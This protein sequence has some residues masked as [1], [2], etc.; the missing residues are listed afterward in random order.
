MA[1]DKYNY[2]AWQLGQVITPE[3]L[4]QIENQLV[5]LTDQSINQS[6]M[7]Q[8]HRERM[9]ELTEGDLNKLTTVGSYSIKTGDDADN[10]LNKPPNE[11]R[12]PYV[13]YVIKIGESKNF[14]IQ[15]GITYQGTIWIRQKNNNGWQDWKKISNN[16]DIEA[17]STT[18]QT[19]TSQAK[20]VEVNTNLN[21]LIQG[22][23]YAITQNVINGG[24]NIP[25]NVPGMLIVFKITRA[26]GFDIHQIY[27][28]DGNIWKRSKIY[29]NNTWS[30]WVS[31]IPSIEIPVQEHYTLVTP[32][33]ANVKWSWQDSPPSQE[34][35]SST[36]SFVTKLNHG[37]IIKIQKEKFDASKFQ[38]GYVITNN[39]Y[40]PLIPTRTFSYTKLVNA[41]QTIIDASQLETDE[42]KVIIQCRN[43]PGNGN[44]LSTS[45]VNKY[46]TI[47]NRDKVVDLFI[48]AGQSNM[49]G[50]ANVSSDNYPK[51]ID[52]AGLEYRAI[53]ADNKLFKIAEPFGQNQN[54]GNSTTANDKIY[55]GPAKTGGM[56]TSF[57]N[58]YYEKTGVPI[59]GIS[60]SQGGLS[61]P[62]FEGTVNDV[63]YS[64][65]SDDI[66]VR[67]NKAKTYLTNNHYVIRHKFLVWLQGESDVAKY[68][69][70]NNFNYQ[71]YFNSTIWPIFKTAGVEK[72][73]FIRI[74]EY[75]SVNNPQYN[76]YASIIMQQQTKLTQTNPDII[77]VSTLL[78]SYKSKRMMQTEWHYT[79]EAYN[80]FGTD[81]GI[82]AAY[83]VNTGKKPTM[84]DPKYYNLYPQ[85]YNISQDISHL[86]EIL[87]GSVETSYPFKT[88][89][90]LGRRGTGVYFNCNPAAVYLDGAS[91]R[92]VT[93]D[94]ISCEA[95]DIFKISACAKDQANS[96]PLGV[97]KHDANGDL[98]KNSI[99][100]PETKKPPE[101]KYTGNL[102][103]LKDYI[104]T[105]PQG[106]DCIVVN[107]LSSIEN[108]KPY[109]VKLSQDTGLNVEK[110]KSQLYTPEWIVPQ[111]IYG[112][113]GHP[114]S[115]YY[116]NT[117]W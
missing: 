37:S 89:T 92:Y 94:I 9:T 97:L 26:N 20:S 48:F 47:L 41:N 80:E 61:L 79:M 83:Y 75:E 32:Q 33:F 108:F 25:F 24:S 66:I 45:D 49:S 86:N 110:L 68:D 42:Y 85:Y 77:M 84:Y 7:L 71:D 81:A 18:I 104:Y 111:H 60:A 23:T 78:A 105:I 72:C 91:I 3:K 116:Y 12:T 117:L 44:P 38:F 73:F 51:L 69:P 17:L 22:G 113:V 55:D 101:N 11:N 76:D 99:L 10:I 102:I 28:T 5:T 15:L 50:R 1:L 74:G 56:V 4:N 19:I 35:N 109:V 2:Q 27:I 95:G 62:E 52:G 115:L 39:D 65:I 96:C 70:A 82:N 88:P 112:V 54:N 43:N 8:L 6:T 14:Y 63:T 36:T 21:N 57:V 34:S 106:Y 114:F 30:E 107:H 29:S 46:I 58:A 87:C 16:Q 93:T 103:Y 53:S 64:R 59:V 67:Y 90:Q 98:D 31:T 13:L 40:N 100:R